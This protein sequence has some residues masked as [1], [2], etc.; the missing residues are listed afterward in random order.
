MN[1]PTRREQQAARQLQAQR[2]IA[3]CE[4][5]RL[6]R[7][8][9]R[10]TELERRYRKCVEGMTLDDI[11]W[12]FRKYD[13]APF[14]ADNALTRCDDQALEDA[15]EYAEDWL[16][17]SS[18]EQVLARS[19]CDQFDRHVDRWGLRH[20]RDNFSSPVLFDA[21]DLDI[22]VRF[23]TE[24]IEACI[25]GLNCY[26]DPVALFQSAK[27]YELLC[28]IRHVTRAHL[29][30]ILE[31]GS[32]LA[33]YLRSSGWRYAVECVESRYC[34]S[35]QIAFCRPGF[36][37]ACTEPP[38]ADVRAYADWRNAH[39]SQI[40]RKQATWDPPQL[41]QVSADSSL[42]RDVV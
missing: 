30:E 6:V 26:H 23:T 10:R 4:A 25:G 28:H 21:G 29:V 41:H 18:R 5:L 19:L 31:V 1:K 13:A 20:K 11:R 22:Y 24:R 16:G 32:R 38:E 37:L 33:E 27:I 17:S 12:F 15:V 42:L 9:K 7:A 39:V 3:Y 34:D 14:L 35:E 8:R 2:G 40:V 36:E